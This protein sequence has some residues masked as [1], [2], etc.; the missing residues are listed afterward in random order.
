[1]KS[2]QNHKGK[3]VFLSTLCA[4]GVGA[5]GSVLLGIILGRLLG[6]AG[7]GIFSIIQGILLGAAIFAR[8][9]MDNA[10]MRFV[11]ISPE[12]V[13][14]I[15]YLKLALYRALMYS[16]AIAILG[17]TAR[18]LL[19]DILSIDM[20]NMLVYVVLA[21]PAMT[22]VYLMSGFMKGMGRPAAACLL[23][24]GYISL[25]TGCILL[26]CYL[27]YQ[28][29]RIEWTAVALMIACWLVFLQG[30]IQIFYIINKA[31]Y[32]TTDNKDIDQ[33]GF[34]NS[35]K[36]FFVMSL[37]EFM[38]NVAGVLIAGMLLNTI[39]LGLFKSAERIAL[40]I[41]FILMLISAIYPPKFAKYYY[42]KDFEGL[43]SAARRSSLV[44][45]M[46]SLPLLVACLLFPEYLLSIFGDEFTKAADYLRI[47]A[48]AQ[49]FNIVTAS[50][51][52]ML[53]MTDNQKV[54][55]NISV[56]CTLLGLMLFVILIPLW[57]ALGATLAL[58]IVLTLQNSIAMIAVRIR[59]GFWIYP[60]L[61]GRSNV[62]VV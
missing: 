27:V 5:I 12:D 26:G 22:G 37:A 43:K 40:I 54:M 4:R 23:E 48:V 20:Q 59:L 15:G 30:A 61:S 36:D 9:G 41:G 42:E 51:G 16:L 58:A 6:V 28:E 25:L 19:G 14:N 2:L 57:G 62:N 50:V 39:E 35:S 46:M 56:G 3:L 49:T 18:Y 8:F 31:K 29:C 55:R 33:P 45:L 24:S 60:Y 17:L 53:N 10:L 21:I 11:G 47:L 7:L 38:Q 13:R 44:G 1:M 52:F 34:L 32:K